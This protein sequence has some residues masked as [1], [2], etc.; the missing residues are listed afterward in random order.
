MISLLQM[1]ADGGCYWKREE[2]SPGHSLVIPN[3]TPFKIAL[4]GEQSSRF[5]SGE[6]RDGYFVTDDGVKHLSANETVVAVRNISSNAFLHVHFR[7][8]GKWVK[9]DRLRESEW[10]AP[11]KIEEAALLLAK[12]KVRELAVAKSQD[13][14]DVRITRAAARLA[15]KDASYIDAARMMADLASQVEV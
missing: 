11:D 13:A 9:A 7:L 1:I 14:D 3:G 15:L 12:K 5:R 6:C 10:S 2:Y 4:E 8:N